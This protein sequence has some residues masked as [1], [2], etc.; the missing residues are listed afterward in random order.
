[1]KEDRLVSELACRRAPGWSC[2]SWTGWVGCPIPDTGLTELETAATPNLDALAGRSACGLVHSVAPGVTPGSGPGHMA[3]FGYDPKEF[4]IGRGILS[5]MGIG[6]NVGP[7]DVAARVNFCTLEDGVVTDR[8]AGRI[9]TETNARLCDLIREKVEVPGIT[10]TLEPEKEHRA[11]LVFHGEGLSAG[12]TDTDPE[13]TGSGSP[14][15]GASRSRRQ[16][17]RAHR[18]IGQPLSRR[19]QRDA[20]QRV[21]GQHDSHA[22][23]HRP[24]PYPHHAGEVP[25]QPRRHRHLP[26][27]PWTG[28]AGGHGGPAHR[29]RLRL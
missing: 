10:F 25:A 3:L 8:R 24:P 27:V 19:R 16:Q 1:M 18:G 12:L 4:E 17:S 29:G 23:L 2:W 26:H 15:G 21:P 11:A 5:A 14:E 20:L 7:G 22:G 28:A 9:P 6:L 13:K